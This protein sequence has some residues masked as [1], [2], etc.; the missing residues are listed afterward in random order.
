MIQSHFKYLH[1]LS[2]EPYTISRE[3]TINEQLGLNSLKLIERMDKYPCSKLFAHEVVCSMYKFP[4]E[5][6]NIL[7]KFS[8][9]SEECATI[10]AT[11]ITLWMDP[12]TSRRESKVFNL[13][14]SVYP[15]LRNLIIHTDEFPQLMA[16]LAAMHI[17]AIAESLAL[18]FKRI[19]LTP[20]LVDN[21]D[22]AGFY[23]ELAMSS[24]D[25]NQKTHRKISIEA[26]EADDG[27]DKSEI[28]R[29]RKRRNR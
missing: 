22:K 12:S 6:I 27:I 23:K 1:L 24:G 26:E 16:A 29:K 10:L 11:K 13:F 3:L 20:Q 25:L 15:N 8:A 21:L 4:K 18:I 19:S 2:H 5:A 14:L 28:V 7:L 17:K 9:Q